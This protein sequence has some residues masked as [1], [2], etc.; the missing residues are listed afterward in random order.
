MALA[1][2]RLHYGASGLRVFFPAPQNSDYDLENLQTAPYPNKTP[3]LLSQ[4]L[5]WL[6]SRRSSPENVNLGGHRLC[7]FSAISR[8]G[9]RV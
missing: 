9:F 1:G 4:A 3:H 2:L 6:S 8:L 7:W 5:D